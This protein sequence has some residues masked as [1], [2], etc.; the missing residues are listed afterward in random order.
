MCVYLPIPP[1]LWTSVAR[2][3]PAAPSMGALMMT[4]ALAWGNQLLSLEGAIFAFPV[5]LAVAALNPQVCD[6]PESE[7]RLFGNPVA[8]GICLVRRRLLTMDEREEY[9]RVEGRRLGKT[10]LE[11]GRVDMAADEVAVLRLRGDGR[12]AAAEGW[13]ARTSGRSDLGAFTAC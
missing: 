13:S 11:E 1:A 2:D 7:T 9:E 12:I 5:V 8:F 4:G 6:D 10:R 3:A